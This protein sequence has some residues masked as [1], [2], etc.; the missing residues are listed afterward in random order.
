MEGTKECDNLTHE[1]GHATGDLE[2]STSTERNKDQGTDL[3]LEFTK[4]SDD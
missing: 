1:L 2:T 3:L 4:S